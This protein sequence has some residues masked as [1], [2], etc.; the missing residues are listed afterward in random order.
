MHLDTC[1]ATA[2]PLRWV[3]AVHDIRGRN[4]ISRGR[5]LFGASSTRIAIERTV[6]QLQHLPVLAGW[7]R[8]AIPAGFNSAG[9]QEL[10]RRVST[11]EKRC[12]GVPG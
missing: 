7:Q 2:L 3:Q 4:G 1:R 5:P 9:M 12:I 8:R 6:N 11:P 10:T